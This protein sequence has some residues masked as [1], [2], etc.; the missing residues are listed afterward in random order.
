[1]G[2]FDAMHVSEETIQEAKDL[3]QLL[4]QDSNPEKGMYDFTDPETGEVREYFSN[5]ASKDE[6]LAQIN[7]VINKLRA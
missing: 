1:M 2:A 6:M 7:S 3:I 5:V 4:Y